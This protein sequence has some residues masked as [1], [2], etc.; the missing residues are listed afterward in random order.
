LL[1]RKDVQRLLFPNKKFGR[2]PA[3]GLNEEILIHGIVE[4]IEK[5]GI[6]TL[7]HARAAAAK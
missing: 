4:I 3:A 5:K 7:L 6:F 2:W 1:I